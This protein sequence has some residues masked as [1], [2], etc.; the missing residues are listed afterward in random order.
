MALAREYGASYCHDLIA[1]VLSEQL[2]EQVRRHELEPARMN[3]PKRGLDFVDEPPAKRH[4]DGVTELSLF[5]E[6][7]S[8]TDMLTSVLGVSDALPGSRN[9]FNNSN[10]DS[11]DS[12]DIGTGGLLEPN[13]EYSNLTDVSR[14][15]DQ[16]AENTIS[17]AAA[18]VPNSEHNSLTSRQ[19]LTGLTCFGMIHAGPARLLGD[20]S[21]LRSKLAALPP[22]NKTI[23]LKFRFVPEFISLVFEDESSFAQLSESLTIPLNRI[24]EIP[25][26]RLEAFVDIEDCLKCIDRAKRLHESIIKVDIN[27]YGTADVRTQV[28]RNLSSDKVYL[29][30]PRHRQSE[31]EYDNPHMVAYDDVHLEDATS[32]MEVL[33]NTGPVNIHELATE[34]CLSETSDRELRG[35]KNDSHV[36]T[37]LLP[38]QAQALEFMVQ[39]EKGPVPQRFQLWQ[40]VFD[41]RGPGFRHVVTGCWAF[42]P[43][44]EIGGGILAD[45]MGMGK[46]LSTLSLITMRLHEGWTWSQSNALEDENGSKKKVRSRATLIVLS[47]LLI[48]NGWLKEINDH[49]DGS[50]KVL[51]YH[52][53]RRENRIALVAD[54]DVV[55]TTYHTLAAERKSK[56]SPLNSIEW[57]RVVL[58]EAHT[59]RRQA[60][61]LYAAVSD[62]NSCH[63]WCLTGTPIQNKLDDLGS[64]LAF[65][66]ADPFD[67]TPMF[68]KYI[69]AP[70]SDDVSRARKNLQLLLDSICLRRTKQRVHLPPLEEHCHFVE[71]SSQERAH[72]DET[73]NAMARAVSLVSRQEYSKTPLGKFQI[74]LHLRILCNHG[75]FQRAFVWN[76]ADARTQREDLVTSLGKDGEVICSCCQERMP[77]LAT[78]CASRQS[79]LCRH[80]LCNE[81]ITQLTEDPSTSPS[82]SAPKCPYCESIGKVG[83][84]GFG[85]RRPELP[86]GSEMPHFDVA[87]YSSKMQ[88]LMD[89]IKER[90]SETKRCVTYF[91]IPLTNRAWY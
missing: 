17:I 19:S 16:W 56:R 87:G 58:D 84:S 51:K 57:F 43:F 39:R 24:R 89:D 83:R 27:V 25:S 54:S 44:P 40:Q 78:N 7:Q 65:I 68:R 90:L 26:L 28:G 29:Q 4:A 20:M 32:G 67:R 70:F 30:H 13:Q 52:G 69:M 62:L 6:D 15:I 75:T 33:E 76:Q 91:I 1:V 66:R 80:I 61:T 74:Q 36:K 45:E 53:K 8:W 21:L 50:L 55:L 86:K 3:P 42:E 38:H 9:N 18:A 85:E 14:R 12:L 49:L 73:L 72:Y 47:S 81:C 35:L 59:I 64:L 2:S 31:V 22:E 37:D 79:G 88:A 48:M 46:T 10:L 5:T 23:C 41:E 60:T 34:I 11:V 77:L 63:R 71:L 82:A